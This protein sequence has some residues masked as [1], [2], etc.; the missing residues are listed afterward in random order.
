M[1]VEDHPVHELT[2]L[3]PGAKWG[4]YNRPAR[5]KPEYPAPNRRYCP[6]GT[7]DVVCVAVPFRMSHDCR[8]DGSL[9]DPRCA[10]CRHQ[11]S[12]QAYTISV[13]GQPSR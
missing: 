7:F 6:D 1:P 12:G 8:H 5:F 9:E 4:C 2:R 10:G 13:T 3:A 11:G